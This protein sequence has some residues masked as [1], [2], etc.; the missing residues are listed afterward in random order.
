VRHFCNRLGHCSQKQPCRSGS[1]AAVLLVSYCVVW[2]PCDSSLPLTS[3]SLATCCTVDLHASTASTT[4]P[5]Y[6][7]PTRWLL[8]LCRHRL[9][10]SKK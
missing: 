5:R 4:V 7:A 8:A 10:V 3:Q 2:L 6:Q 1:C 9:K